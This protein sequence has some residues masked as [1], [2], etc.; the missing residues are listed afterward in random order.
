MLE[1][2]GFT[3]KSGN[4]QPVGQPIVG[5][6]YD[7]GVSTGTTLISSSNQTGKI[8][9]PPAPLSGYNKAFD[10]SAVTSNLSPVTAFDIGSQDFTFE[11]NIYETQSTAGYSG[12]F[13]QNNSA[14]SN[15]I[16]ISIGDNGAYANRLR[17]SVG[18]TAGPFYT[19]AITRSQL[20]NNWHHIALV[21]VGSSCVV[22]VDGVRQMLASGTSTI[23]NNTSIPITT[24][25]GSTSTALSLGYGPSNFY[26]GGLVAEFALFSGA[27]YLGDFTPAYPF[28]P[29]TAPS[30]PLYTQ[31]LSY[32]LSLNLITETLG[33]G[34]QNKFNSARGGHRR[35]VDMSV[36]SLGN[37][38]GTS[39]GSGTPTGANIGRIIQHLCP[40]EVVFQRLMSEGRKV[41]LQPSFTSNGQLSVSL[42]GLNRNGY[43]SSSTTVAKGVIY[44]RFDENPAFVYYDS[45][46]QQLYSMNGVNQTGPTVWTIP[47]Y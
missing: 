9:T 2:V 26:V 31:F 7:V 43:N 28:W 41:M 40:S 32:M 44:P 12:L 1:I 24:T 23:Y 3:K 11:M 4:V 18:G 8:V 46:T 20:L 5:Y 45:T 15:G 16:Y 29:A 37:M 42:P 19:T 30:E 13:Y 27:K 25:L 39:W 6:N 47:S 34:I 35:T 38:S 14:G 33:D 22:Y 10:L 36:G 17:F 21:R